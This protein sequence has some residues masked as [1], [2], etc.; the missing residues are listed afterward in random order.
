[1][2]NGYL[3]KVVYSEAAQD[4]YLDLIWMM[5]WSEL[6]KQL[7][8]LMNHITLS[9]LGHAIVVKPKRIHNVMLG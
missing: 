9:K 6:L 1:M 8:L 5:S 2:V 7:S 4:M 3:E